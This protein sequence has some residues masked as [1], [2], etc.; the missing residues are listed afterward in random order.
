MC[1]VRERH[2]TKQRVEGGV[3]MDNED[4]D[5]EARDDEESVK[6]SLVQ[7]FR[8][9]EQLTLHLYSISTT[10]LKSVGAGG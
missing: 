9:C 4:S 10:W 5:Q 2:V 3:Q 6:M 8:V 7:I 1:H